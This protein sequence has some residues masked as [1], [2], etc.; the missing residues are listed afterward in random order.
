MSA[1]WTLPTTEL[2]WAREESLGILS[3]RAQRCEFSR[4]STTAMRGRSSS[5]KAGVPFR[6]QVENGALA[7]GLADR[8]QL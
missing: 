2:L 6:P 1:G 3:A 5:I 7:P 8:H 4:D